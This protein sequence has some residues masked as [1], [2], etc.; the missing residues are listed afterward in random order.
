MRIFPNFSL[1]QVDLLSQRS[2]DLMAELAIKME[3]AKL[4]LE[5]VVY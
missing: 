1:L 5:A 2:A 3:T 4:E